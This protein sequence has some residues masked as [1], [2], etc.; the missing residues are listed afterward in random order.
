[1]FIHLANH[2]LSNV[3]FLSFYEKTSEANEVSN[4]RHRS[5]TLAFLVADKGLFTHR[6]KN[7]RIK[8]LLSER[9]AG[10]EPK[11][12]VNKYY[13]QMGEKAI[14][15]CYQNSIVLVT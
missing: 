4:A 8:Y 12:I 14:V 6:V 5:T 3:V 9:D 2:R 10:L 7:V 13:G 11:G 15:L 1:M